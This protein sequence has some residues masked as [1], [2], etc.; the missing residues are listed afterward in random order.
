LASRKSFTIAMIALPFSISVTCVV[1][2]RMA[3]LD[4]DRGRVSPKI[5][6]R[7]VVLPHAVGIA[8]EEEH[9]GF[10]RARAYGSDVPA[11]SRS[12]ASPSRRN[13]SP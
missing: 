5:Y 8:V 7:D 13:S 12:S 11:S 2:G 3:S 10:I 9:G 4:A 1:L 6:F